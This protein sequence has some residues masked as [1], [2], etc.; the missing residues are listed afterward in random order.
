MGKGT[1]DI[2]SSTPA[3]IYQGDFSRKPTCNTPPR[4]L[5]LQSHSL[6]KTNSP[7][8]TQSTVEHLPL[9]PN[10]HSNNTSRDLHPLHLLP[11][12][13]NDNPSPISSTPNPPPNHPPHNLNPNLRHNPQHDPHTSSSLRHRPRRTP[14]TPSTSNPNHSPVLR[15]RMHQNRLRVI[16]LLQ[17]L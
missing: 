15:H 7:F 3:S 17:V 12:A 5:D 10:C 9:Q 2:N 11:V 6:F 13:T 4:P 1:I 8:P 16:Q 14:P